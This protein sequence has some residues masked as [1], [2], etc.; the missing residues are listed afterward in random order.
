MKLARAAEDALRLAAMFAGLAELGGTLK[1]LGSLEQAKVE[2]DRQLKKVRSDIAAA[3]DELAHVRQ[4][5]QE[6][7]ASETLAVHEA[8]KAERA[9]VLKVTQDLEIDAKE[10]IAEAET[11]AQALLAQ[12]HA[13]V[14][15]ASPSPSRPSHVRAG[16]HGRAS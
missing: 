9:R 13:T 4:K 12:A 6:S 1:D 5:V 10:I 11:K 2:L 7:V 14:L 3:S 15:A 8:L 16:P